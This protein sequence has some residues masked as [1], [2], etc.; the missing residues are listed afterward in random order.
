MQSGFGDW[1]TWF[2]GDNLPVTFSFIW[3]QRTKKGFEDRREHLRRKARDV[4]V[5]TVKVK[6][7]EGTLN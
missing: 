5:E 2:G 3:G 1:L 7:V 4:G 6:G